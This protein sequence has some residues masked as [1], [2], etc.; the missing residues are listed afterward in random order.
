MDLGWMH[1]RRGVSVAAIVLVCMAAPSLAVAAF[2]GS[3]PDES[4]RLNMPDD[5]GFDECEAD[6]VPPHTAC[7]YF[8]E[9]FVMFGFSPD[10][11]QLLPPL[12]D[13][14]LY[15]DCPVPLTGT[16][17]LDAQ[18]QQAN[19]VA[20]EGQAC[21]Q[22]AGVRADTAWKYFGKY[23]GGASAKVGSPGVSVAILDTGIEWQQEELRTK[24][25]L[26]AAELPTPETTG[27]VE[28]SADDCNNDG[29]FNV[30]DY[31]NDSRVLK[32]AGD[33]EAD[34][35]LDGS[36]LIATFS[37]GDD[38]DA[39]GYVDDIA[40]WDFFDDDNDP[41]DASSCC[42]ASG[43]GTDRA[44]SAVGATDNGQGEAGM[45]PDCQLMPLRVWDTFVVPGDNYAMGVDY[46]TRNGA[47][48]VEGAVG[49]L[50]NSQF[51]RRAFQRADDQGLSLML[52]SSDINSANHNYPTNY[53][54]AVYVAGSLPDTAPFGTCDGPGGIGPVDIP[55]DPP[56]QFT[57]GCEAF[58]D[59]L[60][61]NGVLFT[62]QPTTTSFFR[63][64]NLTQYGG[65]ADIVLMGSTGSENTGYAAGAA[66]LV[67]SFGRLW[68]AGDG[69]GGAIPDSTCGPASPGDC[70]PRLTGNE[71]RQLLTMTAE[72]VQPENTGTIGQADRADEGWD[73]HFGYGR[74]NLAGALA[75]VSNDPVGDPATPP[76]GW[77]CDTTDPVGPEGVDP[78]CVP[79]EAQIDSPDWFAPIDVDVDR[80]PVGGVPVRGFAAAPHSNSGVGAW[81]LEYA[82]GQQPADADFAPVPGATGT[83]PVDGLLGKIPQNI[84]DSLAACD[85]SVAND[86]GRPAGGAGDVWPAD[87]YPS[88]DPERHAFTLR[89][90][91]HEAD[92]PDNLGQYRKTLFAY[93]DDGNLD[94]WPK[95]AGS[96]A[97]QANYVTASGG[98]QSQRLY[99]IDGDNE[100]DVLMPTSSGELW[101]LDSSGD[102]ITSFGGGDGK[103]ET[104]ALALAQGHPPAAGLPVP[105]E[106]L[107]TPAIGDIAGDVEPE[108]VSTAGE[109]VYAWQ[110]DGD[111]VAGFPVRLNPA[112]SSPCKAGVAKPCFHP[113]DRA[114]TRSNHI[115]RGFLSSAVLADIDL[116]GS[117][118]IVA[119]SLDQHIYAWSGDGARMPG[120]PVKLATGGA[121][122]A[123]IVTT[124]AIAELD[125]DPEPEIVAATNE[126]VSTD[127]AFP[128]NPTQLLNVFLGAATGANPVYAINEDGTAV[129]GWPVDVGVAAGDLLPLVLPGHDAAVVDVDDDGVDEVSVSAGTSL[130]AQG[131]RLVNGDGSTNVTYVNDGPRN[132][133]DQGPVLNLADYT[134]IGDVLGTGTPVAVKGGLTVNGVANL[135]AVNQNL[136]FNH[137]EQAWDLQTGSAIPGYPRATDDFQLLSQA[138]IARVGGTG[139]ERQI[140]VGTG[141][142]Q[143]H[144]YGP[145]G[146]EPA[147]WPKFTG[148]WNE[149]TPAVGDADGDGDLDVTGYTREGWSFLW[150]TGS[151]ACGS[152][153]SPANNEW[154]TYHHDEFNSANYG[155]DA[156]P[157]GAPESL[158]AQRSGSTVTLSMKAPGDDWMCGTATRLRVLAANGPIHHPSDGTQLREADVT[159]AAGGDVALDLTD[160][161]LGNA[162]RLAVLFRDEAGN[163]G[164]LKSVAV[165]AAPDSGT[166]TPP[167]GDGSGTPGGG[168]DTPGGGGGGSGTPGGGGTA[169]GGGGA[170]GACANHIE[171][172]GAGDTLKG[173]PGDDTIR[174]LGGD[175]RINGG[176]G[177]DCLSGEGGEDRVA[178]GAGADAIKGGRAKD[179]LKGGSGDDTIRAF[180]GA[181]DR[182]NCGAGDDVVFA[183][184]ARDRVSDNCEKVR[185]K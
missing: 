33:D 92:D 131:S 71:A 153:A 132:A 91:V 99:D 4:V 69:P 139:I 13:H 120:F 17:Q 106:A 77:P 160:A 126:V 167:G 143:V 135:L 68:L 90:T 172:T 95:A 178:G 171:G 157:P 59:Q 89:L 64:S 136:P 36:D 7:S 86:P 47:S 58:Q 63:N 2:P 104:D 25:H 155:T 18:G 24:V 181:R 140:L 19:T 177:D 84:L 123:E 57:E 54:E 180:R 117:L 175:D 28:C 154:W 67:H 76:A 11:A 74:V 124:P 164:L 73:T 183:N 161:E 60:A 105:R 152:D 133:I 82:C 40:G 159:A 138:P 169:G 79:P 31:S 41:F 98:E 66:G 144:A 102:P 147:G 108:I 27:G 158:A 30:D 168:T 87:P 94:G 53:N 42:S 109:H 9:Q 21:A 156:R 101:A 163:W 45:C 128:D 116:D 112:L 65:K 72:D 48:V 49:G 97:D 39:N 44:Q 14:P 184:V 56:D 15:A 22:I 78:N 149:T 88:P 165:P 16:S 29:A 55:A 127:P 93:Q 148:G 145:A 182:I 20:S 96:G 51:A 119:A 62:G 130:E 162:T 100:L 37:N 70:E 151:D 146:V 111:P 12:P 32:T 83:G 174:G 134:S 121:D 46:A 50:S 52:V 6:D 137:V 43:H 23:G 103:V 141:M 166:G 115:K 125:G 35:I 113:A 81:E 179:V 114:I 150:D 118:D 129:D 85:G 8:D 34:S 185:S 107:R 110:L 122:G 26:N 176:R 38:A 1:G 173:S 75:R 80:V 5:P 10:T 170:T 3:D 142:Y 61:D